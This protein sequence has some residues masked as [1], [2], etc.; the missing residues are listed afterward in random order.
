MAWLNINFNS[1]ALHMPVLLDVLIPQGH[2]N[3]KTLYLLHGAGGDHASWITKSRIA[4]YAEGKNI[5]VIMPSGNNRCYV[6]NRHGKDYF[7]FITEE[8]IEKCEKWFPFSRERENRF[9]GGMSM[10]GYGAVYAA[11]ERPELFSAVFSYSGLLNILK[12]YD[13]PQGI[14]LFPVFGERQELIDNGFDLFEKVKK[15]TG[16]NSY[17]DKNVDNPTKFIIAC[18]LQD[19]RL[20]MSSD[21]VKAL[22]ENGF[23]S[24]YVEQEGAHNWQYWDTC[25]YNTMELIE[26][27]KADPEWRQAWQSFI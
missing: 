3:Y 1:D 2:G 23:V 6:N 26:G 22:R 15:S 10:G 5:A 25:I 19:T 17:T 24:A 27:T 16:N 14:E 12:R 9:I 13:K 20:S 7:S 18:G 8:L 21:F 11:L 4:D